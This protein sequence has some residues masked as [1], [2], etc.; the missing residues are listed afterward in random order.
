MAEILG[1]GAL[2]KA[3]RELGI[4]AKRT[5]KGCD[6][7]IRLGIFNYSTMWYF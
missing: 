3:F 7:F 1:G 2:Y 4:E 5:Y 6:Y